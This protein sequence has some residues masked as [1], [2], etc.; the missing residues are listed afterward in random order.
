MNIL[1]TYANSY[2]DAFDMAL[3]ARGART[4]GKDA[5]KR[6]EAAIERGFRKLFSFGASAL[7]NRAA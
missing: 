3:S 1:S 6:D 7:A 2:V 4:T 5:E